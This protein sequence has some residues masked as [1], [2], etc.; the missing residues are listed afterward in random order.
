MTILVIHNYHPSQLLFGGEL[1]IEAWVKQGLKEGHEISWLTADGTLY[2]YDSEG[3]YETEK[4]VNLPD[5]EFYLVGN[6]TGHAESLLQKVKK[7]GKYA[8]V[9]NN[10]NDVGKHPLLEGVPLSITLAPDHFTQLTSVQ[11]NNNYVTTAYVDHTKFINKNQPRKA[12]CLYL[13]TLADIKI[14][15]LMYNEMAMHTSAK[16]AFYGKDNK[17]GTVERLNAIPNATVYGEV[18]QDQAV[19]VY[20]QYKV[21]FWKMSRYGCFGRTIVEAALCGCLLNVNRGNFGLFKFDIDWSSRD[22]IVEKLESDLQSFWSSVLGYFEQPKKSK[23]K[24]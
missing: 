16:Y 14:S 11:A 23:K 7:H 18:S 8:I 13:G 4:V 21:F 12:E 9:H 3:S 1:T 6:F 10:S 24:R 20:N 2:K 5:A 15:Q 17:D 19:D 22:S